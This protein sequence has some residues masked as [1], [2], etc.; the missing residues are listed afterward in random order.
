MG[1][2]ALRASRLLCFVL[3]AA[4]PGLAHAQ[5]WTP[6]AKNL[7]VDGSY[8][9]G[10]ATKTE[11]VQVT[12]QHHLFIPTVEYGVTDN[13]AISASLPIIAV[14]AEGGN[15]HGSWDDSAFHETPTD[16]RFSARYMIPV[17]I[18]AITPQVG[19]STPVRNYEVL[20]NASVGRGLKALYAGLNLGVN[21]DEEIPRTTL[22]ATYEFAL[23][24]KYKDAGPEGEALDQNFSAI[25][26]QVAHTVGGFQI[27]A[28]VDYRFFHGGITFAE[29]GSLT[30]A[31]RMNHDPIL[32]ESSLLLGGGVGYAIG[33]HATIYATTRI[34]VSGQNT[35]N[36]SLFAVGGSWDVDL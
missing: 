34:F 36:A 12:V 25:A 27:H 17:G 11:N 5:A 28:G 32:K 4:G 22:Q 1:K 19:A 18:L 21:L 8:Q 23:V 9:L 31:E 6:E 16:F 14:K 7:T 20:G 33:E 35:Q 3:A 10:Y 15:P 26:A 2:R 13:L 29:F 30:M 24:E